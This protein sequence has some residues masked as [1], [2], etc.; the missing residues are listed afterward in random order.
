MGR[1][2]LRMA[3]WGVRETG[4]GD[5]RSDPGPFDSG[6]DVLRPVH[7]PSSSP[8]AAD[9]GQRGYLVTET[10]ADRDSAGSCSRFSP[11]SGPGKRVMSVGCPSRR[12]RRTATRSSAVSFS[13]P[14]LRLLSTITLCSDAPPKSNDRRKYLTCRGQALCCATE[15]ARPGAV[16]R[17]FSCRSPGRFPRRRAFLLRGGD[18]NAGTGRRPSVSGHAILCR[19]HERQDTA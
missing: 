1:A 5:T 19:T 7:R 8:R 2:R 16:Y 15:G 17:A 4:P 3:G 18:G 11:A 12:N 13:E 9:Q 6:R 10:H 14:P